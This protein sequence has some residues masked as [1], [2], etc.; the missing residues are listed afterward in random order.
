MKMKEI[1]AQA[2]QN[3]RQA[4]ADYRRH[5]HMTDVLDGV[6]N[7]FIEKLARD[8]SYAKQNLRELFSKSPV[9]DEKIDALVIN[10]TR[11]HNPDYDR[12]RELA[13][14]ILWHP[15]QYDNKDK[16]ELFVRAINFFAYPPDADKTD[17]IEAI[18]ELAPKAYAPGKK[19]SRI[20]R[21]LCQEYGVVDESLGSEFQRLYAQFADELTSKKISFKLY[22]S[23]NPAHFIT[24]SNPKGDE[25][26][27]TMTSCH[28]FNYTEYSYNNGCSGYA[29]D[30]VTFIVF[31]VSDPSDPETLNNRKTTRQ[32]FAYKP[33]NGLLMQSRL[34]N[35]SGGTTGA[36]EESKLYR[37]LVQRE[38]SV[39]ENAPNLWKTYAY[40]DNHKNCVY[41]GD[42]FGGYA[43][44]TYY[45]FEGKV[46]VRNDHA[47]DF[48]PLEVGTY[49][50]CICCGEEIDEGLYCDECYEE[51][52][53][54][55][56]CGDSCRETFIVHDDN[57][58]EMYV[59]EHCL[60]RYYTQCDSCDEHY[61]DR[62]IEHVD[63]N[64]YCPDCL[65]E[66]C[67]QCEE[68]GEWHKRDNMYLVYDEYGDEVWVCR[69]CI[70]SYTKCRDCEEMHHNDNTQC[71]CTT[72]G[73]QIVVCNNCAENYAECPNCGKRI[74]ICGDG[75]CPNCS[76]KILKDDEKEDE[77]V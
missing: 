25:R 77:A 73:R 70:D 47:E 49:G 18:K 28:S 9:W 12:I 58:G 39:L 16:Y 52:Y 40:L 54:C 4:I 27:E 32:I 62:Q 68:C 51:R 30:E 56:R 55:D 46:S 35:T 38:I 71:I 50:L 41:I 8:S 69:D 2:E 53:E 65:E 34:Y 26:G 33:G 76:E 31:T 13:N 5:T 59:C 14:D 3:I 61:P 64:A 43:D 44:W 36:Q 19:P 1:I 7:S 67:E 66:Y 48:E 17:A 22:V 45:D 24:M 10:G 21:A 75:T 20:F 72:D 37:D 15:M 63:G 23:I 60:N 11:T 74:E 57:S 42:G 6:S 29:R